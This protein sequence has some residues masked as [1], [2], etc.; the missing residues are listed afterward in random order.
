[1]NIK[2]I[3][4]HYNN[5]IDKT[6]KDIRGKLGNGW[7]VALHLHYG[8]PVVSVFNSEKDINIEADFCNE[9]KF[10]FNS[11]VKE[12]EQPFFKS[13]ILELFKDYL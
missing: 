11:N 10:R 12:E 8:C 7:F 5:I 2:Q 13:V 9:V 6:N 4:K 3:H 1:M